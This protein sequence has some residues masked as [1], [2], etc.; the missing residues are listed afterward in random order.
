M[1]LIGTAINN[2]ITISNDG[3][4]GSPRDHVQ[5]L[6]RER[7]LNGGLLSPSNSLL[8]KFA[9]GTATEDYFFH[10]TTGTFK[11]AGLESIQHLHP[12]LLRHTTE[13]GN[14]HL[15]LFTVGSA[16]TNLQ[17]SGTGI[18]T[19]VANQ[20]DDEIAELAGLSPNGSGEISVSRWRAPVFPSPTSASSKSW[21]RRA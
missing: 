15:H 5:R 14:P 10:S 20:N 17:T 4:F 2:M 18:G 9:I 1:W 3:Y 11:I 16:S 12:A 6:G 8:G 19:Y 7:K 21:R 13:R